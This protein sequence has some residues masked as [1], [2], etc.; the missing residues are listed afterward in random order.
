M[1]KSVPLRVGEESLMRFNL[2]KT[3][4]NVMTTKPKDPLTTLSTEDAREKE[5][6][7]IVQR[8]H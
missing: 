6:G 1:T 2:F 3:R 8:R 4:T 7:G 5:R